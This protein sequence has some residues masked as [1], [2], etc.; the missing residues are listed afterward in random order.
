MLFF[1]LQI[2][3]TPPI[4]GDVFLS[5][6]TQACTHTPTF[7]WGLWPG[8]CSGLLSAS[9]WRSCASRQLYGQSRI[10]VRTWWRVCHRLGGRS[11]ACRCPPP[12][13]PRCRGRGDAR[14]AAGPSPTYA[15]TC[16][17]SSCW[18]RGGER[19]FVS[20]SFISE[21][22]TQT[23]LMRKYDLTLTVTTTLLALKLWKNTALNL[24]LAQRSVQRRCNALLILKVFQARKAVTLA[25]PPMISQLVSD[26][27]PSAHTHAHAHLISKFRKEV[28]NALFSHEHFTSHLRANTHTR[29]NRQANKQL[30]VSCHN[31]SVGRGTLPTFRGGAT[32]SNSVTRTHRNT[33][34]QSFWNRVVPVWE[35]ITVTA[36]RPC[37][38]LI[39][40]VS[41]VCWRQEHHHHQ[42]SLH[43]L[44]SH[45]I[46]DSFSRSPTQLLP[47]GLFSFLPPHSLHFF[48]LNLFLMIVSVLNVLDFNNRY[49]NKKD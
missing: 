7:Q 44:F 45:T 9:V 18:S 30:W 38:A 28:I 10:P 15:A 14:S 36:D 12:R 20:D 41:P 24:V 47:F 6:S 43:L 11:C 13:R 31:Q 40:A 1:P 27:H 25:W 39:T 33:H 32:L 29:T 46:A 22:N 2:N 16:T 19:G 8:T 21:N 3:K 49:L 42:T 23:V 4:T 26:T 34:L 5:V 37:P 35:S 17:P 48:T